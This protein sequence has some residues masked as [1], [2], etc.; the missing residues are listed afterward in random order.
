MLTPAL[1]I[2]L[3]I[4]DS[5]KKFGMTPASIGDSLVIHLVGA[6][7]EYEHLYGAMALEEVSLDFFLLRNGY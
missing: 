6:E 2:P 7:V 4:L 5:M 3:T 1:T